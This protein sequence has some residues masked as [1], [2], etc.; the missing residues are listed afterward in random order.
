MPGLDGL[1]ALSVLAVIVYHLHADWMPGGLL[2]V[3]VFFVL[4]GYLI[5]DL[6]AAE[7][8]KTGRL[9]LRNFWLR[10]ARR[11]LPAMLIMLTAVGAFVAWGAPERMASLRGDMLAS[12]LYASNWWFIFREVSY[13]DSFGPPSPLGHLWSL[14]VEEQFYVL[15]PLLFAAALRFVKRRGWLI[16]LTLAGAAGSALLM[17]HLFEPG[18]DPSRIYYGTD[19]RAFALLIGAAF[20]LLFPSS[21]LGTRMAEKSRGLR[22]FNL[23]GV[24]GLL[25]A[26]YMFWHTEEYDSFLYPGGF[27]ILS[28]ASGLL[29]VAL[30][31]PSG[32]LGRIFGWSPLRW[33]GVRSY[34]LYLW[35]YPVIALTS[36]AFH[37]GSV[38][39][40]LAFIQLA[41]SI[42]LAA[43]S[44]LLIEK[45][46]RS[47]AL[48]AWWGQVKQSRVGRRTAISGKAW[49]GTAI[50]TVLGVCCTY[51]SMVS[52]NAAGFVSYAAAHDSAAFWAL[53][54]SAHT[55]PAAPQQEMFPPVGATE[56]DIFTAGDEKPLRHN[57][58]EST[59]TSGHIGPSIRPA[60]STPTGGSARPNSSDKADVDKGIP[61]TGAM[62]TS[63]GDQGV[64]AIG[65]SVIIGAAPYLKELIP[66]IVVDGQIGRQMSEAHNIVDTLK[67][68]GDLGDRVIIELGTNGAFTSKQIESLLDSL[69]EV[70]QVVLVNT[71]VP[72]PWE[73]EVNT[74][75]EEASSRYPNATLVNWYKA[76]ADK[77]TYFYSDGV[78]LN[79][80]GA[81]FYAALIA[82]AI[83]PGNR[84]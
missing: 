13:F 58:E 5:T 43:A 6:L 61:V 41:A 65:D 20:A 18:A 39:L 33:L 57:E 50:I 53:T 32:R 72:R 77:D 83:E 42:G 19:T 56:R 1:R 48:R 46:I 62:K 51:I 73:D 79:E 22:V 3:G 7:W 25:V 45:P 66:D 75:L 24:A 60:G 26:L 68:Q 52:T 55:Q 74:A 81:Q 44:W 47:G 9:D 28:F 4:S 14:A 70:K 69:K 80:E 16:A 82:K 27:V 78:H 54:A 10:R 64:T 40:P 12:M 35:H 8:N 36:P 49:T 84:L 29:I 63:R 21:K 37:N 23:L 11:L 34:A 15:W 38:N 31:H 59:A 71:R 30:A 67:A 76:S 17:A 2:G